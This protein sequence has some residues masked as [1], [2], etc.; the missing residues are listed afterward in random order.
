MSDFPW[1]QTVFGWIHIFSA[2]I[3]VGGIVF[4]AVARAGAAAARLPGD[5]ERAA[6][7]KFRPLFWT[8]ALLLLVTGG[9]TWSVRARQGYPGFYFH[10]VYTKV[11][12]Y[13]LLFG[14]AG[15]LTKWRETPNAL[16][17][18]GLG[19][20]IC[21]ALCAVILFLSAFMRRVQPLPPRTSA[22]GTI[23]VAS[24]VISMGGRPTWRT[25]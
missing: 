1:D 2:A 14:V 20:K 3:V 8:A 19:L 4:W 24:P 7:A 6:L 15:M 10:V 12:L 18:N 9:Y 16:Q 22:S 25:S 5:W 23:G 21:L 11:L 13:V 17:R